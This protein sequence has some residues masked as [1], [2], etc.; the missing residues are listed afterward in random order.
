MV[1]RIL[2]TDVVAEWKPLLHSAVLYRP[3]LVSL[4]LLRRFVQ[5]GSNQSTIDSF[6]SRSLRNNIWH[7]HETGM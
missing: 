1:C 3:M 4:E 2:S 5:I 7:I 6:S